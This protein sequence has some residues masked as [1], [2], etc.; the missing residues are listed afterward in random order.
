MSETTK[1]TIK[2]KQVKLQ[3]GYFVVSEKRTSKDGKEYETPVK[4]YASL[5]AMERGEGL[6]F[7]GEFVDALQREYNQV[8]SAEFLKR[9]EAAQKAQA[10]KAEVA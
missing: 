5:A 8:V 10:K 6:S 9:K 3:N 7:D 1:H 2:G 4:T